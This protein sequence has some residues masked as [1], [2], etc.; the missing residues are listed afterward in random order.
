MRS[1]TSGTLATAG[2]A[3]SL[4]LAG[5]PTAPDDDDDWGDDD[6]TEGDDDTSNDPVDESWGVVDSCDVPASPGFGDWYQ[7]GSGILV[8]GDTAEDEALAEQVFEWYADSIADFETR[9]YDELTDEE[10]EE[11]LFVIGSPDSNPLLLEMNG[12]LPVYFDDEGFIF[13]GYRWDGYANGIALIHPS[14]F[15]DDAWILLYVGNSVDGSLS[16]FTVWTGARDYEVVRSGWTLHM[17]GDLCRDGE[18]WG[19]YEPWADDFRAAWE[20]WVAGLEQTDTEN[21]RFYYAP[22]TEAADEITS[23]SLYQESAYDSILDQLEVDGL[24]HPIDTYLYPDN[25]TK[26]DVTGNAGNAH[27]VPMNMEVHAVYG[28]GVYAIGAHEDVHVVAYHRIGEPSYTLMGEG[29]AVMI[30]GVWWSQPLDYWAS[31]F[32]AQGEI[33]PLTQ[34]MDDFW[35]FDDTTT[36]PLAGHFVDFLRDGWGVDTL[37]TLYVAESLDAA[38]AAE[39]GLSTGEVE[40]A[41]LA[42]IE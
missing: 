27:A 33:P 25:D 35:G 5:C 4:I 28:D 34:L 14:P 40:A 19:F 11:N 22:G 21:H 12:D 15:A 37:K 24:D 32:L 20:E 2:A 3:L 10:R 41:W 18:Q 9:S 31:Q 8:H 7:A 17:E 36:Y 16:M 39:L 42:T 1:R 13:G 6:T 29:L 30:D 23:I 38:F 26:G